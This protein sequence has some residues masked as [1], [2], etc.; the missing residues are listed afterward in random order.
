VD[1]L[2]ARASE[3]CECEHPS[4]ADGGGDAH[5]AATGES[6]FWVRNRLTRFRTVRVCVVCRVRHCGE[7]MLCGPTVPELCDHDRYT[8]PECAETCRVC[9][10]DVPGGEGAALREHVASVHVIDPE[11]DCPHCGRPVGH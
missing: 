4:H 2:P 1:M 10:V 7:S 11:H 5:R 3:R 9:G 6:L 8:C